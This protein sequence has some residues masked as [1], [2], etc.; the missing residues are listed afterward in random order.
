MNIREW[1]GYTGEYNKESSINACIDGL[2]EM[3]AE[4]IKQYFSVDHAQSFHDIQDVDRTNLNN[5]EI[6]FLDW[7]EEKGFPYLVSLANKHLPD[8]EELIAQIDYDKYILEE[9]M[10]FEFPEDV[11]SSLIAVVTDMPEYIQSSLEV[12]V[13]VNVNEFWDDWSTWVTETQTSDFEW[14]YENTTHYEIKGNEYLVSNYKES[15]KA[16]SLFLYRGYF[17]GNFGLLQIDKE[18][19]SNL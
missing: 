2:L 8:D 6:L 7:L 11:R 3:Y 1:F 4:A 12:S 19:C 18:S 5:G 15:A 17:N 14:S 13:T 9:E 16:G 10:D